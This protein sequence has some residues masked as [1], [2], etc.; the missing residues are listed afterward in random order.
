MTA[1][2]KD[3]EKTEETEVSESADSGKE[4]VLSDEAVAVVEPE[5]VSAG[6]PSGLLDE[7]VVQIK[8]LAEL[9]E[10]EVR[11]QERLITQMQDVVARHTRINRALLWIA[12][13]TLMLVAILTIGIMKMGAGQM[14]QS[15]EI[16][17]ATHEIRGTVNAI[18]SASG[19]I[20]DLQL[21][22]IKKLDSTIDAVDQ[23]SEAFSAGIRQVLDDH[24]TESVNSFLELKEERDT[25]DAY[26]EEVR[27]ANLQAIRST[28][29]KL[30]AVAGEISAEESAPT[31]EITPP[32]SGAGAAV[33]TEPAPEAERAAETPEEPAEATEEAATPSEPA[34]DAP[35][36]EEHDASVAEG[37]AAETAE[38][39]P[40]D[41][42]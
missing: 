37:R 26:K 4:E 42:E 15:E 20:D 41:S 21:D 22:M 18:K 19:K 24:R 12:G 2:K 6:V 10:Q 17:T 7:A 32:E 34:G 33:E 28:I 8:K 23:E 27:E 3:T 13:F 25:L 29:E 11:R 40:T 5:P 36:A 16:A 31:M 14:D 38:E 39:A 1:K 30:E 35:T 9:R